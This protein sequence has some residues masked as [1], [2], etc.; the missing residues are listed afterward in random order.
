LCGKLGLGP[1]KEKRT[2]KER[3]E[4][5]VE[6]DAADGNPLTTADSHSSLESI[7]LFPQFPQGATAAVLSQLREAAVQL[8]EASFWSEEWG[9]PEIPPGT[10]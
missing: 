10:P 8:K 5:L 2:N 6:T 3:N 1:K 4:G 7:E 9:A